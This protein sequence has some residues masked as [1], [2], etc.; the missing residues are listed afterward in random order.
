MW[1]KDDKVWIEVPAELMNHTFFFSASLA[2]GLGERFFWPGLMSTGQLVSLRK[3]GNNVQFVAHNLKVRAPEGTPLSTALH[4]SY[5]D[6]LLA[7]TPAAS[8]PHPQR[9]SILVDAALLLGDLT[10]LST[11]LEAAYRLPYMPDRSNSYFEALRAEKDLS[12]LTARLHYAGQWM[13]KD[14]TR[15]AHSTA[16]TL[17]SNEASRS[18]GSTKQHRRRN[19]S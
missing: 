10:G 16:N 9:K 11:R 17:S 4:E 13:S 12:V 1:T 15:R 14:L 6:S 8:A 3:V 18:D 7:S 19:E 2:N 5:S